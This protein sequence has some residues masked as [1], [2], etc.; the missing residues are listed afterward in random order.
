MIELRFDAPLSPIAFS[1]EYCIF[2]LLCN[3]SNSVRQSDVRSAKDLNKFHMLVRDSEI[4]QM[5]EPYQFSSNL[6]LDEIL[7]GYAIIS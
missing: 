5:F 7:L 2:R 1:I 6:T 4:D 3:V